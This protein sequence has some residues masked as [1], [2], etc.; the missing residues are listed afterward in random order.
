VTF[1]PPANWQ[2]IGVITTYD[3][4]L[5]VL[6]ARAAQR[7]VATG[8]DANEVAGLPSGY[9]AKLIGAKPVRR[10]GMMSLGPLLA[11]LGVK[12]IA[13]EDPEAIARYGSRIKQRDE[14]LV[15]GG[16]WEFRLTHRH[17]R[18]IQRE[19][20]EAR[21]KALTKPER[22]ALSLRANWVRWHGKKAKTRR[23][24]RPRSRQAAREQRDV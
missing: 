8:G 3:E 19:G 16:T 21:M 2:G 10:I 20:G 17:M 23:V 24:A 11:I 13:A 9:I 15:R 6:R 7:H 14:R 12:L 22:R 5:D 4:L 1:K 18:K